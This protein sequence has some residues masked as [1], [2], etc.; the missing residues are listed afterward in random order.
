MFG[1]LNFRSICCFSCFFFWFLSSSFRST[2]CLH[3]PASV[4]CVGVIA[5]AIKKRK[6]ENPVKENDSASKLL[7][8]EELFQVDRKTVQGKRNR[9]NNVKSK[10]VNL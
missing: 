5:L 9:H 3:Y 1:F 4:I 8:H 6:L 10:Q 7:W 2:L